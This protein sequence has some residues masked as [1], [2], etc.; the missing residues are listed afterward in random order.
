MS[1]AMALV[2]DLL[3]AGLRAVGIVLAINVAFVVLALAYAM[4]AVGGSVFAYAVALAFGILGVLIVVG[5]AKSY[6]V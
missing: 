5:M 4:V 6:R 1:T 3:E 2:D